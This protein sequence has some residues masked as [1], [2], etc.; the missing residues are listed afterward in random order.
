VGDWK[1]PLEG[2]E[3]IN[4]SFWRD[5]KVFVTGHTG[6]KGGWLT[7][8][9]HQMGAKVTG[10]SLPAP[11]T[12][13]FFE[14]VK[15]SDLCS[16]KIGDIRD[17]QAMKNALEES[18]AEIVFHM[19]AQPLVRKSYKDPIETYSTNVMGTVN[20]LEAVRFCETVQS[21]VIITTD[22]C[23]ENKE[24]V[25]GYRENDRL[26]GHDPYSNSKACSELVVSAYLKS[27][28]K[29]EAK[30]GI[31][32]AR[33]GN[34]I[35]GGD[36]AEDRLI[37][38]IYR[39]IFNNTELKI[40]YP[41]STRPWQHVL[42]PLSGYIELAEKLYLDKKK[43]SDSFNFG[44]K[45]EDCIS[46]GN[47]ILKASQYWGY[48]LPVVL[49]D[50]NHLHEAKFLKLDISKAFSSLNWKPEWNVDESIEKTAKWYKSFINNEDVRSLS[51][52]QIREFQ[53]KVCQ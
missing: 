4:Y 45:D 36:F 25:W 28:F 50:G 5:K 43:Y 21:C 2:M 13:S 18:Q 19:A 23:Y 44:P 7:L 11:T 15:L 52:D 24:W 47:L 32:S 17:Y 10:Y 35:G 14:A 29:T 16:H 37:P 38:D 46:V 20:L 1:S 12:P 39:A 22:K 31:A 34:V 53:Y 27:F 48:K 8:W 41:E 42:V 6:F 3:V 40:R 26:G 30:I 9:L 51:L 49:E 33:A